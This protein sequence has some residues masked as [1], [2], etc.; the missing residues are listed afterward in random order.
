MAQAE[1][2][3]KSFL[4]AHMYQNPQVVSVREQ[5]QKILSD[6]FECYAHDPGALPQ[7][8]RL[9]EG[10][11]E[12]KAARRLADFMAGMTDRFALREHARL[13]GSK[14]SAELMLL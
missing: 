12:A 8:W 6:L 2:A 10:P 9:P 4:H 13:F 14:S 1:A 3:L 5:A 7:G 11:L